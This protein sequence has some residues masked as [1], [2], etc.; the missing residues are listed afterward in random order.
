MSVVDI[1][2]NTVCQQRLRQMLY[3]TPPTRYNTVSPY[4]EYPQYTQKQ[5]DM[6]RKAEILQYSAVKTNTKTNNF[7][8]SQKWGQ[9][10][11]GTLQTRSY[12]T[13][14]ERKTTTDASDNVIDLPY[15]TVDVC[16]N[17][18]RRTFE[19]LYTMKKAQMDCSSDDII[20]T[21]TSASGIPGPIEYLTLD[22][23]VPLYNYNS[24]IINYS[25]LQSDDTKL[26]NIFTDYDLS[27]T[28]NQK[29]WIGALNIRKNIDQ[30]AYTYTIQTPISIFV[31]GIRKPTTVGPISFT[32]LSVNISSISLD[33]KYNNKSVSLG[34]TPSFKLNHNSL[35]NSTYTNTANAASADAYLE[36]DVSMNSSSQ[37]YYYQNYVGILT[38]SNIYL[39]TE[40]G[41]IYDFYLSFGM[42]N[43]F[44]DKVNYLGAFNTST[45]YGVI[46]NLTSD[47]HTTPVNVQNTSKN[48]GVISYSVF[49]F[50]G[51]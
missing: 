36:F 9:L 21:P 25:I 41:Y 29:R 19:E 30:Y 32:D 2:L 10:V 18:F 13:L 4:V 12:T 11:N 39:Y 43:N 17:I 42:S 37:Y 50:D 28:S 15:T 22:R 40:P 35:S 8:K 51:V 27:F 6:R 14:F 44:T 16:G 38:I 5:F 48:G 31:R 49:A 20:P 3:T 23:N 33:I 1:C 34:K 46:C 26:W 24:N 47:N 7:T 45:T